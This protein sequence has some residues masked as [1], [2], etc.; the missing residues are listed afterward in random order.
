[1]GFQDSFA[2]MTA[3]ALTLLSALLCV[4]WGMLRWNHA[5]PPD[6][7]AEEIQQWAVEED[8]AETKL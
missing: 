6:E 3:H 1:M 7:P 4:G 2:V 8:Q 5:E